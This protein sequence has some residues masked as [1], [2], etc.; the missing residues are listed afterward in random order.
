MNSG[1]NEKRVAANSRPV[2]GDISNQKFSLFN[3]L[4]FEKSPQRS[5]SKNSLGTHSSDSCSQCNVEVSSCSSRRRSRS[6]RRN[7]RG[8]HG[9][10]LTGKGNRPHDDAEVCSGCGQYEDYLGDGVFACFQCMAG[11][12]SLVCPL[13]GSSFDKEGHCWIC[14]GLRC[15]DCGRGDLS[16]YETIEKK[17]FKCSGICP[18]CLSKSCE[19]AEQRKLE[20]RLN[21]NDSAVGFCNGCRKLHDW[22]SS[23]EHHSCVAPVN[24]LKLGNT[25]IDQRYRQALYN[26]APFLDAEEVLSSVSGNNT[27]FPSETEYLRR[28]NKGKD[29]FD[30][31]DSDLD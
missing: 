23:H 21:R 12:E 8:T 16:Q 5:T 10:L 6:P 1:E 25:N 26:Y 20:A 27:N 31:D 30:E 15:R 13:C 24:V 7:L 3:S 19:C 9:E 2:L 17:C 22:G 18:T 4:S 29:I 28:K 11:S 14:E